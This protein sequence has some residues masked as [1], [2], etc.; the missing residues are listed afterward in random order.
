MHIENWPIDRPKPYDQNPRI[1]DKA[2]AA[3]AASIREFGFRQPI[4]VDEEGVIIVGHTRIK[5]AQFLGLETVPVHV[6]SGLTAEQIRAYRIADNQTA[7]LAEW[8]PGL[9][10]SEVSALKLD[11]F[12]LNL[13][14]FKQGDLNRMLQPA[15]QVED[16]VIPEPPKV[17]T[18]QPGQIWKLGRH[19][20]V[21]GDSTVRETVNA[22][23]GSSIDSSPFLMATDP[24][25]GVD[26]DPEWRLDA[27]V[28]KPHQVVA[29]GTIANDNQAD[30][31][32]AWMLSPCDVAYV[33]HAGIHASQVEANLQAAGY[34]IRA[35]I[36]WSKPSL[37]IGR[38]HYHWQHEPCWYAV[39]KGKQARWNGD[40]KQSTVWPIAN[41]HRTQGK[42]DDGKTIHS[43]QKPVECMARAMRNHGGAQED[44]YDPFAGSGS[45]LIAAE[46]L[47][48][49]CFAVELEPR[50]CDVIIERYE[51][52]SGGKAVLT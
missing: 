33:W 18:T 14:G 41:M 32:A 52:V 7:T 4:V 25:Y 17:A 20:L 51:R 27:G 5:A 13:L 29:T 34:E 6:A 16:D 8:D 49:R 12:D 50:Y 22:L 42:V 37:V 11:G 1:N 47:G 3:V 44:V 19:R 48:R 30:W 40:R 28:C 36:I 31:T 9:L 43:S 21:C 23:L 45:T 15:E 2:V 26:Y 46:R 35:Q 10:A 38:G 39:R 24:P